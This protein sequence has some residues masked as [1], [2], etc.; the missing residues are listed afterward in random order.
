MEEDSKLHHSVRDVDGRVFLVVLHHES[1]IT[2]S[3]YLE[4]RLPIMS[5]V[6][7][8]VMALDL[9]YEVWYALCR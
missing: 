4:D 8:V 2:G 1:L 9:R 7:H 6:E 5:I 3:L